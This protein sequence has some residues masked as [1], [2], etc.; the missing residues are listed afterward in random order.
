MVHRA[1]ASTEGLHEHTSCIQAL[2]PVVGRYS[3][4]PL[5][6]DDDSVVRGLL[7]LMRGEA[8]HR[9]VLRN[10]VDQVNGEKSRRQL[11]Q[12]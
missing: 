4:P 2:Q 10:W 7:E 11:A 5:S 3:V 9:D 1:D 6:D 8:E 12:C